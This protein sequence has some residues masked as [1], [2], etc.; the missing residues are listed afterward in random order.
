MAFR[1]GL[2]F[3]ALA[4]V[5]IPVLSYI[6][7]I[8][9]FS[10]FLEKNVWLIT[11]CLYASA[12]AFGW[13]LGFGDHR[14][15]LFFSTTGCLA[16]AFGFPAMLNLVTQSEIDDRSAADDANVP[17]I[18]ASPKVIALLTPA[19][20]GGPG[21]LYGETACTLF[22]QR[23][24][25]GGHR[26]AVLA[27]ATPSSSRP[28]DAVNLVRYSIEP[29]DS[30]PPTELPQTSTLSNESAIWGS[31]PT[32]DKVSELIENGQCLVVRLGDIAEAEVAGVWSTSDAET[33]Q[34]VN[35]INGAIGSSR[36]EIF[37]KKDRIW[38][39]AARQTL[40]GGSY[41]LAPFRLDGFVTN[42]RVARKDISNNSSGTGLSIDLF[43]NAMRK[44]MP[45]PS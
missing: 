18:P 24:L 20:T 41:A 37:V 36:E 3:L 1:W 14:K 34:G 25:F 21:D 22:C 23:L 5:G 7:M 35:V 28:E 19:S 9:T 27:G 10:D 39:S 32:S 11:L 42:F 4:I 31:H 38:H 15:S 26:K 17:Q 29:Q 45:K 8:F 33:W 2:G 6:S 43:M 30:C 16:L 44:W 13:G 40:S 12:A